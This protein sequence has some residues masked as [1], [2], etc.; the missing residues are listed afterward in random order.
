VVIWYVLWPLGIF[1]GHLVNVW[2][3]GIFCGHL[4]YCVAIW[5]KLPSVIM[6][7]ILNILRPLS[8]CICGHLVYCVAI[9]Y[10]L[11]SFGIFCGHLE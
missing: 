9:W 3:F 1:C 7:V 4:V 2:S 6:I 5:N 10:I 8:R 11:W